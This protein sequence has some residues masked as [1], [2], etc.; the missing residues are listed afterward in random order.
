MIGEEA[1]VACRIFPKVAERN[2]I[3]PG[4]SRVSTVGALV[5]VGTG[6]ILLA[7]FKYLP[8]ELT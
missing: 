6:H 7:I 2:R 3:K 4:K 5:E 8:L 1:V